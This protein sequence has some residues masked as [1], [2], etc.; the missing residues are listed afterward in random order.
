MTVF[1]CVQ[2]P[3]SLDDIGRIL[4]TCVGPGWAR[5][6]ILGGQTVAVLVLV[7]ALIMLVVAK[8]AR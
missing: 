8:V 7:A 1:A 5:L 4:D 3:S 2:Q 6:A